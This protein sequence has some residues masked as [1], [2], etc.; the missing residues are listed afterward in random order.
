MIIHSQVGTQSEQGSRDNHLHKLACFKKGA[1]VDSTITFTACYAGKS[2]TPTFLL[3]GQLGIF[4]RNGLLSSRL[5][6]ESRGRLP[7]GT[8]M[9][10]TLGLLS[11]VMDS[12]GSKVSSV[13]AEP[14][15][16]ASQT[17]TKYS[18]NK[19]GHNSI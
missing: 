5:E 15:R 6:F 8:V 3:V 13:P 19:D 2:T 7:L 18:A 4:L 10:P 11:S 16:N 1:E 17:L 9:E 14:D 12:F